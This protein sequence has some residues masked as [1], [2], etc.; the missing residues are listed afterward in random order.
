[1]RMVHLSERL[2]RL[3]ANVQRKG[4]VAD[5]GC[6][7][8]FTS[9]Y[10]VQ[11]G[12]ADRAV[13][14]DI[15]RGPLERAQEHILQYQVQDKVALRLSDGAKELSAGEADTILISGMGGALIC[16][17]L[18]ESETVVRSASEL[19][20]SPQSEA[21]LVRRCIHGLGFRI[22]AEEM[23]KEQGKYYVVLRAVQGQESYGQDIDYI[24]G[25]K[26]LEGRDAVF[27]EYLRKERCRVEEVLKGMEG[28]ELSGAGQ[29]K[30][31]E[32]LLA[33]SRMESILQGGGHYGESD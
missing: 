28:K 30:R 22:A 15:N 26:L 31:Q 23:V 6:D 12:L 18:R 8:G 10:L 7:H 4:V 5:I 33:R 27:L 11:M 1:M 13:A 20:L 21:W 14:M 9:I 17:I 19:V 24:Y 16:R 3:A 29:E 25:R 2:K 32:L